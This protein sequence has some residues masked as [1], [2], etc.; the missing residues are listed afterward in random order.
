MEGFASQEVAFAFHFVKLDDNAPALRRERTFFSHFSK[1]YT[2][3][4]YINVADE[5]KF[6]IDTLQILVTFV[7]KIVYRIDNSHRFCGVCILYLY[8][9]HVKYKFTL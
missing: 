6:E 7:L 2:Q 3:I 1:R 5:R 9:V 4:K 8:I